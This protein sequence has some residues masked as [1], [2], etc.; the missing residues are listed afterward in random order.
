MPRTGVWLQIP[1]LFPPSGLLMS[2]LNG[3]HPK[4]NFLAAKLLAM[5]NSGPTDHPWEKPIKPKASQSDRISSRDIIIYAPNRT[6]CLKLEEFFKFAIFQ[7][8][9]PVR[10][11]REILHWK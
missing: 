8:N 1:P 7:Q 5:Q 9:S 4:S 6:I 10:L 11:C 3:L 2:F